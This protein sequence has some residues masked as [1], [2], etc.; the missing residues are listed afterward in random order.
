MKEELRGD[1]K[2]IHKL[3][4]NKVIAFLAVLAA[5]IIGIVAVIKAIKDGSEIIYSWRKDDTSVTIIEEVDT[6]NEINNKVFTSPFDSTLNS[7]KEN[8]KNSGKETDNESKF[9]ISLIS[10]ADGLPISN[11]TVFNSEID[12][13]SQTNSFGEL[14]IPSTI[15]NRKKSYEMIQ[16]SVVLPNRT[17]ETI[18]VGLSEPAVYKLK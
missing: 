18:Y 8:R 15:V 14:K 16:L 7:K 17:I 10:N 4:K 11:C 2:I 5:I 6:L 12:F 1:K 13:K 9:V 3:L